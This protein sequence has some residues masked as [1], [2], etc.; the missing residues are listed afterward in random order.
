MINSMVW[1][2]PIIYRDLAYIV[3]EQ[4]PEHF[5]YYDDYTISYNPFIKDKRVLVTALGFNSFRFREDLE[6]AYFTDLM[7]VA[8]EFELG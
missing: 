8:E 3:P 2:E 1:I 4:L 6:R 7:S 5:K